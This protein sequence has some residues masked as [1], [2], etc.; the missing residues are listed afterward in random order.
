MQ[1]LGITM[2]IVGLL[3]LGF[4]VGRACERKVSQ[5]TIDKAIEQALTDNG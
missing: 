4:I 5:R 2:I 3:G 1:W